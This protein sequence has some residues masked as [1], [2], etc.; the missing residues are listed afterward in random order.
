MNSLSGLNQNPYPNTLDNLPPYSDYTQLNFLALDGSNFME[1]D[2]DM[3]NHNIKNLANATNNDEAVNLGQLTTTLGNYV[4]LNTSQI[5]TGDKNFTSSTATRPI[6]LTRTT[7]AN[8]LLL[9]WSS[10]DNTIRWDFGNIANETTFKI[11]RVSGIISSSIFEFDSNQSTSYKTLN[12]NNNKITNLQDGVNASD[13]VNVGQ[14]TALGGSYVLKAGDSM[15]GT[16]N[17]TQN[18]ITNIKEL[19]VNQY[20]EF[21][22]YTTGINSGWSLN[23]PRTIRIGDSLRNGCIH[24]DG[25]NSYA[26]IQTTTANLH[27]DVYINDNFHGI[28]NNWY[29]SDSNSYINSSSGSGCVLLGASSWENDFKVSI[30]KQSKTN[31]LKVNGNT[32]IIGEL[33]M[34]TNKIL[35]IADGALPTD[36]INKSQLDNRTYIDTTASFTYSNEDLI[37][38]SSGTAKTITF[39]DLPVYFDGKRIDIILRNTGLFNTTFTFS[40]TTAGTFPDGTTSKNVT[41]S[42][43]TEK[44]YSAIIENINNNYLYISELTYL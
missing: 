29:S 32:K 43:L 44:R 13:G 20:G 17:M 21:I 42:L 39:D 30:D 10:S 26:I 18:D 12:M 19:F 15:T 34:N 16:L 36:G 2:L 4:T 6:T 3:N 24:L 28:Y 40:I 11:L 41:L 8:P 5:I 23:S 31:A 27:M 22:N 25:S 38:L 35:N 37:I 33:D 7:S 14:L 1:A 9:R